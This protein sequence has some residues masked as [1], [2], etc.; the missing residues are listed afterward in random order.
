MVLSVANLKKMLIT[1]RDGNVWFSVSV[2]QKHEAAQ[3]AS[4]ASFKYLCGEV[5]AYVQGQS[6][7]H[8]SYCVILHLTQEH[9]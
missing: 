8:Q 1:A 5:A 4:P 7:S 9:L 2:S 6:T 3:P